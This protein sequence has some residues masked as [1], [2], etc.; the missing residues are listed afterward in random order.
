MAD[1]LVLR[2]AESPTESVEWVIVDQ[3]GAQQGQIEHGDLRAVAEA[4]TDKRII[5]LVPGTNVLRAFVDIPVRNQAKL[6]QAIPFAMEDQLAGNIEELH[7][8]SGKRDENGRIPVAV[9]ERLKMEAWLEQISAVGLDLAG[10]YTDS[11]ALGDM[12][13]TTILLV[14]DQRVTIRDATGHVAATDIGSIDALI[15]VW[16]NDYKRTDNDELPP[17]IN[18]LAYVTPECE[19]T[20]QPV[21]DRLRP[22]V[23]TLEIML[24]P[25]GGL[26]RMAAQSIGAAGINLLQ[27]AYAPRSS[28]GAYWPVWRVAA[29]LLVGLSV[30][31]LGARLLEISSLN[32]QA[33]RLDESIE[34]AI[35]YTFPEVREI[36]DARALFDSKLR[37]LGGRNPAGSGA[38]FLDTLDRVAGAIADK[39][40]A[41]VTID[42][43][44]YRSGIMELKVVAPDVEALDEIRESISKDAG[45]QAEIQSANPDGEGVRGRLQIKR[46]GTS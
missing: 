35:H 43:I 22:K 39:S 2:F 44:N 41:T 18:L 14:E 17:P 24:L 26:P 36:R 5:A 3:S 31:L 12:P 10:V 4:A 45:L 16:L 46:T 30:T 37:G 15:D 19:A 33:A 1:F 27:G 20:L 38:G 42:S 7:F 25:D 21:I 32:R 40:D 13:N 29:A 23:E 34:Q 8:A 11:D 28:F 9:V 6:L